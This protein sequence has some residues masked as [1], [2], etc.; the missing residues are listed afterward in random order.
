MVKVVIDTNVLLSSIYGKAGNKPEQVV[1]RWMTGNIDLCLS[2]PIVREYENVLRRF[3]LDNAL[4]AFLDLFA[5]GFHTI[6]TAKTPTLRVVSDPD[7][8]KFV[9]CAVALKAD[10]IV[11]GDKALLAVKKYVT[12]EIFSPAAFLQK[13][14]TDA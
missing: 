14:P 11:S 1:E 13:F 7:D 8:D 6:F 3:D 12:V 4:E 10:Y 9:E 2:P 5:Q